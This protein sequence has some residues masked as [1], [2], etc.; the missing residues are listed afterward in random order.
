[1]VMVIFG[2]LQQMLP[3][4][5]GA[6]IPKPLLVAN[7]T[8]TLLIF[9]I[10]CFFF[11]FY[12]YNTFL[13][14]L[15]SLF[16]LLGLGFF[17]VI[18]LY[19]LFKV[20]NRSIIVQGMIL[21]L[22][23]FI[24]GFLLGIDLAISHATGN[25]SQYHQLFANYHY[26]FV[27]GGFVFLLIVSITFQVVPMFWVTKAF[28]TK[29]QYFIIYGM[30]ASL[31]LFPN[32]IILFTFAL[33]FSFYTIYIITSRKRKLKDI[34][35][36]YYITSMVFLA[37]GSV[38]GIVLNF[39]SLPMEPLVV[40]LGVG[41]VMSIISGMLYKIIPFLTWFH[42]SSR[43][44]FDIPTMRDMIKIKHMQRQYYLHIVGIIFLFF[45]SIVP[46]TDLLKL[47]GVFLFFSNSYLFLNLYA[48]SKV[49]FKTS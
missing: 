6:G 47:G 23:F 43:G 13:L 34:S 30:A 9:G 31:V 29:M 4:V 36:N 38:Y 1:M 49:Y 39:V 7:T 37:L 14:F 12:L 22:L 33:I 41:F 20:K 16:L 25:L 17:T 11:G 40:I 18:C 45:G 28:H 21:S 27:L 3:V 10:I 2:A 8:Y 15:S 32:P 44:V 26:T 35:V 24:G 48:A 46:E 19:Q 5:A 42:L